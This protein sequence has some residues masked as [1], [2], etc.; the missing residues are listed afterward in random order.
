MLPSPKSGTEIPSFSCSLRFRDLPLRTSPNRPP[1]ATK[2]SKKTQ[3]SRDRCGMSV[4]GLSLVEVLFP[5]HLPPSTATTSVRRTLG[6][7]PFRYWLCEYDD[8]TI[9]EKLYSAAIYH[10][11][12]QEQRLPSGRQGILLLR[13]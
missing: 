11:E 1:G 12:Q 13:N 5:D 9:Q 4:S 6:L 8:Y 10:R 3:D 7:T 2:R